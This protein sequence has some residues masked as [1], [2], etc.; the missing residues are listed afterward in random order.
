MNLLRLEAQIDGILYVA[1]APMPD[2]RGY[3]G[4]MSTYSGIHGT[5]S[6]LAWKIAADIEAGVENPSH[7]AELIGG[8]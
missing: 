4:K 6:R 7:W 3:S 5:V 2:L 8:K 1:E